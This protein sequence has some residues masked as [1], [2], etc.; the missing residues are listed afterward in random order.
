VGRALGRSSAPPFVWVPCTASRITHMLED[1]SREHVRGFLRFRQHR[2]RRASF[3]VG[4][5]L[6]CAACAGAPSAETGNWIYLGNNVFPMDTTPNVQRLCASAPFEITRHIRDGN[7]TI[8]QPFVTTEL[9]RRSEEGMR[10]EMIHAR[11]FANR[12]ITKRKPIRGRSCESG[13]EATRTLSIA[14]LRI[15]QDQSTRHF[16]QV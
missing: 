11:R 6:V 13:R 1:R 12:M 3:K 16:P 15:R 5:F 2:E 8:P 9:F 4:S 10:I 7:N 14:G